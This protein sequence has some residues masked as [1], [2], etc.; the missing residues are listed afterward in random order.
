MKFKLVSKNNFGVALSLL[1]VILLSQTRVFNFLLVTPLGRIL[2]ISIILSLA[3]VNKI[4]GVV[5]VLFVIVI[6]SIS[7]IGS[8]EGF[9]DGKDDKKDN[10]TTAAESAPATPASKTSTPASKTSTPASK[11]STQATT[12]A[13]TTS[14]QATTTTPATT[15]ANTAANLVKASTTSA[16]GFDII[17]TEN[18]IKRGKQSNQIPVSLHMR[19]SEN[20]SPFDG[21]F[22]DLFSSFIK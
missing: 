19:E 16:E 11:T 6:F 17:G 12:P 20:I 21:S 4:L 13:T 18:Y 22:S 1:L 2:L 7:G 8:L 3:Y 15:I 5:A 10:S 9:T 14:T